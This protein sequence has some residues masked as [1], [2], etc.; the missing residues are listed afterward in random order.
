VVISVKDIQT[1]H[2]A[3]LAEVRDRVT[4]D[5]RRQKSIELAKSR[6]DEI[7]KRAKA[8][9]NLATVAKSL[10]LE[11]K[12]S[13]AISRTA[14]I[15]DVG[16]AKQFTQ[17]FNMQVGQVGDPIASGQNWA[18]YRVAQHDPLNQD[19]FDKQKAKLQ[20]QVLQK[21]RQAAYDLFRSSLKTRLQQEGQLHYNEENLKRLISPTQS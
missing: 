7:A 10:G 19:D 17:A 8:G 21:K 13:E 15:P 9:E 6:A 5:F 18:V 4:S 20:D 1:A 3:T 14:S 16:N 12:T 11:M 2:P